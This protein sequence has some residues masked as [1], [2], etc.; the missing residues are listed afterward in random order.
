[1]REKL[2][3]CPVQSGDSRPARKDGGD[4]TRQ[5]SGEFRN[6]KQ[7]EL[8]GACATAGVCL[9]HHHQHQTHSLLC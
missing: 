1:M 4:P 6:L 9:R 2:A 5:P 8:L 7:C 3:R